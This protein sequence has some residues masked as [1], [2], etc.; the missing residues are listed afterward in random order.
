M[1]KS[2]FIGL[3]I[4]IVGLMLIQ[5]IP[6]N[7][8]NPPIIE[9]LTAPPTVKSVLK[10]ACY[11]CHSHETVWP[12]YS[13]IAPASWLL[14]WDVHEGREELNFSNWKQYSEQKKSKILKEIVEEI[15][16]GEMPPW[17]YIP[18]HPEAS[19]SSEDKQ[20]IRQWAQSLVG[21][22]LADHEDDD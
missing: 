14:A 12:W 13:T 3:G 11:D 7:L 1:K 4:I 5:L 22:S 9:D 16:E 17:F 15:D 19:L 6:I 18:L 10:R 21:H 8:S 2:L 20:Q